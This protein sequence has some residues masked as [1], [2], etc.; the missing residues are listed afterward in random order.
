MQGDSNEASTAA[1]LQH[2]VGGAPEVVARL[3]G[4]QGLEGLD[5][6]QLS[7]VLRQ[8]LQVGVVCVK[9]VCVCVC[10]CVCKIFRFWRSSCWPCYGSSCRWALCVLGWS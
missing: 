8:Q 3:G 4:V 9:C 6:A 5:Q 7:A 1:M 10:V 2:L